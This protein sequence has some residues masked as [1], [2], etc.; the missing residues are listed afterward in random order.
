MPER[1]GAE[2]EPE[3]RVYLRLAFTQDHAETGRLR[4]LLETAGFHP[5]PIEYSAHVTQAGDEQGYYVEVP[6]SEAEA[7]RTFLREHGLGKML[8]G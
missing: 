5:L 4:S 2:S 1:V 8:V 7:A 3:A 6:R